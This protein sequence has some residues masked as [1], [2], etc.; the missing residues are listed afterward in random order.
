MIEELLLPIAVTRR[1]SGWFELGSLDGG[2]CLEELRKLRLLL[3]QVLRFPRVLGEIEK[4]RFSV[5][6]P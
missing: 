5:P 6:H 1:Q 2:L 3:E 4:I